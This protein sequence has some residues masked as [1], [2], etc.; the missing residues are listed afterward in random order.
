VA[1]L[2]DSPNPSLLSAPGTGAV[3][4]PAGGEISEIMAAGDDDE[5]GGGGIVRDEMG[6]VEFSST[7]AAAATGAGADVG[8]SVFDDVT[9][10]E[11]KEEEEEKQQQHHQQQAN[12]LVARLRSLNAGSR[13]NTLSQMGADVAAPVGTVGG[14]EAASARSR[15]SI[16][17]KRLSIRNKTTMMQMQ[18]LSAAKSSQK[19]KGAMRKSV[20]FATALASSSDTALDSSSLLLAEGNNM[21]VSSILPN[22]GGGAAAADIAVQQEEEEEVVEDKE[23]SMEEASL[24]LG[25]AAPADSNDDFSLVDKEALQHVRVH[26][27]NFFAAVQ[28]VKAVIQSHRSEVQQ[29]VRVH[30]A[31]TLQSAYVDTLLAAF[32]LGATADDAAGADEGLG[33]GDR[34]GLMYAWELAATQSEMFID[35]LMQAHT[36]ALLAILPLS[37]TTATAASSRPYQPAL[38]TA[39][40]PDQLWLNMSTASLLRQTAQLK[41]T[42]NRHHRPGGEVGTTAS[43]AVGATIANGSSSSLTSTSSSTDRF[44]SKVLNCDPATTRQ[45][46]SK[47]ATQFSS[48][49]LTTTTSTCEVVGSSSRR[50]EQALHLQR[51]L[52]ET[53]L[54]IDIINKLTFCRVTMF[55]SNCIRVTAMLSPTVSALLVFHISKTSAGELSISYSELDMNW[56]E[57]P[58]DPALMQQNLFV[59]AFFASVMCSDDLNGVLCK[60]CLDS[61]SHPSDIPALLHK[62]SGSI[63]VLRTSLEKLALLSCDGWSFSVMQAA[64]PNTIGTGSHSTMDGPGGISFNIAISVPTTRKRSSSTTAN[65]VE[66]PTVTI[67]VRSFVAC[68]LNQSVDCLHM[69]PSADGVASENGTQQIIERLSF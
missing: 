23:V 11:E 50:A 67:P 10:E 58:S 2:S 57:T 40:D 54:L 42:A 5:E 12:Q 3:A 32:P 36:E 61:L 68:T 51:E 14:V 31:N 20:G 27:F 25:V 55:Q 66:Q 48:S 37:S 17:M 22:T 63:G 8:A 1:K 35:S 34:E 24:L 15:M 18:Q 16:G 43:T 9:V 13:S 64:T 38:Y 44:F 26:L 4:G 19:K 28:S 56:L 7:P 69:L 33:Q 46:T 30:L 49:S 65:P 52:Q 60:A 21:D 62:V 6:V 45:D 47:L 29:V 59:S 41:D 39:R 53:R